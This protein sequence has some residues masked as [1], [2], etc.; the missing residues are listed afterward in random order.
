QNATSESR[1]QTVFT[2]YSTEK[3]G[4]IHRITP[5]DLPRPYATR[6][7]DNGPDRIARPSNAWPQAPEGFKVDL[8]T[9]DLDNPREIRTAPDGDLFVAE[10]EPGR[11]KVLHGLNQDGKPETTS[12]FATGLTLPFGIAFYPPGPNPEYVYVANTDSVVRFPYWNGDL[13]ARG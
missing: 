13:K 11:V 9:S 5:A 4:V 6:A 3:P 1:E 12:V 8:F 7:A 10:S 2:D